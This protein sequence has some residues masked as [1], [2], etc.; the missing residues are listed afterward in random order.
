MMV[1]QAE[2]YPTDLLAPGLTTCAGCSMALAFRLVL[3][4]VGPQTIAV[5]PPGCD[6]IFIGLGA[7]T[8]LKIPALMGNLGA[9]AAYL[10]GIEAGLEMVGKTGVNVLAFAGDGATVDI[11]LQ[12]LSGALERGHD[13]LY[14]C[15]DNEGYMNTGAQGSGSTPLGAR[16]STT[17][18]GKLSRRK[19]IAQIVAAHRPPYVATASIAYPADFTAKVR[20]GLEIKGPAFIHLQI[21]CPTGWRFPAEKTVEVARL[22]VE[23]GLFP[24]YEIVHQELR[25][26]YPTGKLKPVVE[27][28]SRQERFQGLTSE[29]VAEIQ[30]EV[31][32]TIER[33]RPLEFKESE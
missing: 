16:T 29:Q 33:L 18:G 2:G 30:A 22:A 26:N 25:W 19:D 15:S 12:S 8:P 21:P 27:Y 1:P 17:P 31:N 6:A 5:I 10:S 32:Q 4:E 13:F 3:R 9:T 28:L 24:L 14:I 7:E 23:T 11:G 20:H